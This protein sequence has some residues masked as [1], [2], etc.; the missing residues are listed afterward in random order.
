MPDL[1]SADRSPLRSAAPVLIWRNRL[2]R[3]HWEAL[4]LE[5]SSDKLLAAQTVSH[6]AFEDT[7]RGKLKP[8]G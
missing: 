3:G 4:T 7:R 6:K 2:A 8:L 1:H 5:K